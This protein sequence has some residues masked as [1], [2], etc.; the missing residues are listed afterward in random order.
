VSWFK[1][2][3]FDE[4]EYGR[5]ETLATARA[6]SVDGVVRAGILHARASKVRLLT[7]DELDPTW[8]PASD[9]R[10]TV[11]E[12]THHLTRR[13][14]EGGESSAAELLRRLGGYGETARE[15]A[16]VLYS[17]CERKGWSQE[18][19]D[20]NALGAAWPE[21]ARLAATDDRSGQQELGV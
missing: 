21:I 8:D 10:L 6:V 9:A 11:W 3:R 14:S 20:Y 18:A 16:H 4:A 2:Y 19:L 1:E 12:A 7:R 13:L 15:L 17:V 5:A